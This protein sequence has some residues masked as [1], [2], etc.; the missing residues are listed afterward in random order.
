MW[1]SRSRWDCEGCS[2]VFWMF[3]FLFVFSFFFLSFFLSSFFLFFFFLFF[4]FFSLSFFSF[5][6]LLLSA[7]R[8]PF[9]YWFCSKCGCRNFSALVLYNYRW[10][11]FL[12]LFFFDFFLILIVV[13]PTLKWI[14]ESSCLLLIL[15]QKWLSFSTVEVCFFSF[16]F[17]LFF[18]WSTFKWMVESSVLLILL[19]MWLCESFSTGFMD[20]AC[21]FNY[22]DLFT[23]VA[24]VMIC[25][26]KF[27]QSCDC[28][29]VAIIMN[30]SITVPERFEKRFQSLSTAPS[31]IPGKV[32]QTKKEVCSVLWKSSPQNIEWFQAQCTLLCVCECVHTCVCACVCVCVCMLFCVVI[33][34]FFSNNCNLCKHFYIHIYIYVFCWIIMCLIWILFILHWWYVSKQVSFHRTVKYY[35]TDLTIP[36]CPEVTLCGAQDFI[37]Q[38]QPTD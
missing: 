12:F 29:S 26:K 38:Q 33:N 34:L 25:E 35:L 7:F 28:S 15:F 3:M 21:R 1:D 20:E 9:S 2:L 17:I 13:L 22:A 32:E 31:P 4:V 36:H 16:L 8:R 14:S 6:L 10:S 18:S 19:Q 37:L 23:V 30:D 27:L 24:M 11:L 5:L